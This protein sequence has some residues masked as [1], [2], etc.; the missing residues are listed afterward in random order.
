MQLISSYLYPNK[1]DVFTNALDS[2]SSERY[3]RVYNRNLK[4]YR[5]V[6][7]RI[8]LQV[9]NSDQKS[10]DITGSVVV[11]NIVTR[12]GKNLI[13]SKDCVEHDTI[14]G[15][16]YVNLTQTELLNL[17]S[18]SYNYSV[19]KETR[20]SINADEH[21]VTA[22]TPLYVDSQYGV[23]GTIEVSGDVLGEVEQSTYVDTFMLKDPRAADNAIGEY[24]ISSIIDTARNL[25][26]AQSLHTF[27]FYCSGYTGRVEIQG[28]LDKD[29]DPKNWTTV[30]TTDATEASLFY[31]NVVGKYNW[32]R[33]KH[34][35][36]DT[37]TAKFTVGQNTSG[38]Y[39]V[40]V[41]DGGASY[42]IGDTI[43]IIGSAL[44]G[45]NGTNDLEITVTSINYAGSITGL[46][47]TGTS[48][49]GVRSFVLFGTGNI[50][51]GTIDKVLYR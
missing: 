1:L 24:Y 26:T 43:T 39:S 19:V 11:F 17:E 37:G 6:D 38:V 27:Q 22:R 7:N 18:G 47:W 31:E 34:S 9:R 21:V 3:R 20:T 8:D 46:T 16:V 28:S 15:R 40:S 23:I 41:Y 10:I 33:I 4:I 51:S 48:I 44:G 35:T 42:R 2:W 13:L 32:F 36:N 30:R 5:S 12:E 45:T 49:V 14:E 29:S 50:S 25:Q